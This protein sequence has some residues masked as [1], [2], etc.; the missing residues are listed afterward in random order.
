MKIGGLFGIPLRYATNNLIKAVKFLNNFNLLFIVV[1]ARA[2]RS[3][4]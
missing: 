1:Q 4:K 3:H 2:T